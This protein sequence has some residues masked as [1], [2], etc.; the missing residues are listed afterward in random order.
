MSRISRTDV[1]SRYTGTAYLTTC[2]SI[3]QHGRHTLTTP[4][5]PP[6][7]QADHQADPSVKPSTSCISNWPAPT[8]PG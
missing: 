4:S 8:V 6:D 1:Y 2:T 7:H 5:R 3:K